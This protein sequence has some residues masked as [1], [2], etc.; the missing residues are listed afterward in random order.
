MQHRSD[1]ILEA[2][3]SL[4]KLYPDLTNSELV[5]MANQGY[6]EH[7]SGELATN[8]QSGAVTFGAIL[9]FLCFGVGNMGCEDYMDS[10][11]R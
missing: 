4:A 1:I 10:P 9:D 3:Q 7:L 8:R 5:K 2:S 6:V 11:Y